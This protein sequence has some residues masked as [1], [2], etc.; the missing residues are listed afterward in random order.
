MFP[1]IAREFEIEAKIYSNYKYRLYYLLEE[2][3]S[4]YSGGKFLAINQFYDKIDTSIGGCDSEEM[5]FWN[6]RPIKASWKM[7]QS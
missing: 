2:F 4:N 5:I 7:V 6:G 3:F 1:K